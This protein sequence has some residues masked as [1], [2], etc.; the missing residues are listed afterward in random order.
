MVA[1]F[2]Q[3]THGVCGSGPV[4]DVKKLRA[5]QESHGV[6][7]DGKMSRKTLEAAKRERGPGGHDS[8]AGGER[9]GQDDAYVDRV[10]EGI[11]GGAEGEEQR[12]EEP[13]SEG[14]KQS[15]ELIDQTHEG[16]ELTGGM[17]PSYLGEVESESPWFKRQWLPRSF[18]C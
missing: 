8:P 2:N 10:M 17:K 14:L 5:W 13:L 9:G 11:V 3:I 4:I 18:R 16:M 1:E 15:G 12:K 6:S 7:P